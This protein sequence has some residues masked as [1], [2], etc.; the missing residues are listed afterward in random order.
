[1]KSFL[2]LSLFPFS[3]R[4][5]RKSG[6]N[7]DSSLPLRWARRRLYGYS[8]STMD[9]G[10]LFLSLSVLSSTKRRFLSLSLS[11]SRWSRRRNGVS[12]LSLS[13]ELVDVSMG[14]SRRRW[15]TA[16]SLSLWRWLFFKEIERWSVNLILSSMHVFDSDTFLICLHLFSVVVSYGW[17]KRHDPGMRKRPEVAWSR[18]NMSLSW[19]LVVTRVETVHVGKQ[20]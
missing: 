13:V 4:L 11:L 5:L 17:I 15:T 7:G 9:N 8:S 16:S 10:E 18:I 19:L 2:F 12:S 20:I 14:F 6:D 1:V 3:S